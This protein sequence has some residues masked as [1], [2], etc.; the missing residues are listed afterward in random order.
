MVS[1]RSY[2]YQWFSD[3]HEIVGKK[4]E[5]LSGVYIVEFRSVKNIWIILVVLKP[6]SAIVWSHRIPVSLLTGSE[7]HLL[8]CVFALAR[9]PMSSYQHCIKRLLKFHF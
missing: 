8:Y 6:E 4:H 2:L 7:Q 1:Q 3:G 5:G 9:D